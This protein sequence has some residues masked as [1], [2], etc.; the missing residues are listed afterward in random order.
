[1]QLKSPK[2]EVFVPDGLP[3]E[4][5]LARTTHLGIGAHQDDLEIMAIDGIL[6]C[7]QRADRW[8]TGV[9]VTDG[10][11]SARNGAYQQ[12]TDEEMQT[13][14]MKEQKNAA[15]VGDFA[16]A[17]LM[18]FPSSMVKDSTQSAPV[19]DLKAVIEACGPEVI[20]THNLADKHPTHIAVALRVITAI[21]ALPA[22]KRPKKLYGCEV[23]R[24]LGWMLDEE[25]VVFDCSENDSL[26]M[27]LVG[28]FDSQVAGGKRYDLATMGR[29]RA[30]ATYFASH[31]VDTA[32]GLSFSMDLTPLITD[33]QADIGAYVQGFIDRF[34]ADVHKLLAQAS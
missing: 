5:A 9:V 22:D 1:M 27:A 8:F 33:T 14:R 6:N 24:D 2:A 30:N 28:L 10:G 11:G 7:F 26:Q 18:A 23:W 34:S 12:Y 31:Q 25:K 16:A 19:D 17:V 13:V 29:R 4:Q 15:L 3:V 21:R 32:T 20:Y